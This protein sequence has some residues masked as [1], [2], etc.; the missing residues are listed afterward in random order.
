[1][2]RGSIRPLIV[3]ISAR[4]LFDLENK[5]VFLRMRVLMPIAPI[6]RNMKVKF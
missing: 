1:M 3:G 6:K 2:S 5:M 4:A